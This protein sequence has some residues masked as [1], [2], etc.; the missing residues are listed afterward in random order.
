MRLKIFIFLWL[1]F[2]LNGCD[3]DMNNDNKATAK[4]ETEL[5]ILPKLISLPKEPLKVKWEVSDQ[6]STDAG[7]LV[8]LLQYT[9]SDYNS[10][11][12]GSQP[13]EANRYERMD[14]AFYENWV[15][16][17]I[18]KT[19]NTLPIDNDMLELQ[20]IIP[21]KPDLFTQTKLSPFVNGSITPLG[22]GFILVSLY[23]M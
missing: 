23:S 14:S 5:G 21:L 9:I 16:Q 18:R 11:I 3:N 6:E 1:I 22:D 7:S 8:A 20:N 19:I 4:T 17:E 10:I 2:L 12:D 15:P 13:F